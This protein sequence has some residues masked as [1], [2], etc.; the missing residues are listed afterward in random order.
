M[1]ELLGEIYDESDSAPTAIKSVSENEATVEGTMELREVMEFFDM[2]LSG[3]PTD[4]V[5]FWI[6]GHVKRIPTA[7]ESFTIDGLAIRVEEASRRRIKRVTLSRLHSMDEL[8]V[9]SDKNKKE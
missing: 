3:K 9:I 1:E 5:N 6:L 7:G 8:A 2:E 4:T